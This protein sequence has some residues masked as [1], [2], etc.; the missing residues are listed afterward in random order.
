MFHILMNFNR[1]SSSYPH[2]TQYTAFRNITNSI[3]VMSNLVGLNIY[4]RKNN[5][6]EAYQSATT[7]N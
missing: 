2:H 5:H 7:C 3:F 6:G 4:M 1:F